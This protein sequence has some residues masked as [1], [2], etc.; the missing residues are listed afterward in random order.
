MAERLP[1]DSKE[2]LKRCRETKGLGAIAVALGLDLGELNRILAALGPPYATVDLTERHAATLTSFL[3]RKELQICESLR[4]SF[5]PR[6][7]AG[8]DL[9]A[10]V[11]ARGAP[12]PALP[13]GYG[14]R[15]VELSQARMQGWLDSWMEAHGAVMS[16]D[17]PAP[18]NQVEA[19]REANSKRL[20]AL[21]P[22]L[23][24]AVLARGGAEDPVMA[25]WNS[26]A[27]AEAAIVAAAINDGWADFDRCG[28]EQATEWL[29]RSGLWPKGWPSLDALMIT[30]EER[31]VRQRLDEQARIA[32]TTVKRQI[33]HSGGI[34]TFGVDAMGS[35]ADQISTL[36]SGN[37]ALLDTSARTVHG[38]APK[39]KPST[40]GG[41]GGGGTG[42]RRMTDE[43]R[44][45]IGFFGETI[46][47]EWLKHQYGAKR[48]IDERCW[49]SCYRKHVC[50]EPGNDSLGYDFE[51]L[52]GGTRWLFEVKSTTA[53]G[54][55][56]VQSIELGSTE[57]ECAEVCR[58]DRRAR[59]R[60][61]YITD[62][63]HP[64]RA[65]IFVL[66]N[67]RGRRGRGFFTDL[68][69]GQRLYFPLKP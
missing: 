19:V 61:L 8:E 40:G 64:E 7:A 44:S 58:A 6:F 45:L 68:Q 51:V 32:A 26:L 11:A 46:A 66:P 59:Y 9:S 1:I 31:L 39:L 55:A 25:R 14:G 17:L 67:P 15:E 3:T 60:I 20:R 49:K 24:T 48:A 62:A 57:F 28:D 13:D 43:E 2:I 47:F 12:R 21:A 56:P 35:L 38:E 10:Y 36:V 16:P 69:A 27:E 4:Q 54:P 42:S 52:N 33:E 53:T 23:R 22:A 37:T 29:E 65:R 50:G 63:L 34:F 41:R 5:R 18:R 30:D